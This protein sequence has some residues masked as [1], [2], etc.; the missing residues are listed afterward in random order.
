MSG[1]QSL[2]DLE[3]DFGRRAAHLLATT[4]SPSV[5]QKFMRLGS[6]PTSSVHVL[7]WSIVRSMPSL[8]TS[9]PTVGPSRLP[10]GRNER[11]R[12]KHHSESVEPCGKRNSSSGSAFCRRR[13]MAEKDEIPPLCIHCGRGAEGQGQR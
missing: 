8:R 11:K 5:T 3:A 1:G 10:G 2:T 12:A 7:I 9:Q 4:L 13:L 6:A